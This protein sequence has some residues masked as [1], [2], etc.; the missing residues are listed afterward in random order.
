MILTEKP[1][2]PIWA[3]CE[4][5][6]TIEHNRKKTTW[7]HWQQERKMWVGL[8]FIPQLDMMRWWNLMSSA[9]KK[10]CLQNAH[11]RF[12]TVKTAFWVFSCQKINASRFGCLYSGW[13]PPATRRQT[14]HLTAAQAANAHIVCQSA[15]WRTL[16]LLSQP[17]VGKPS[18]SSATTGAGTHG[19]CR[20]SLWR[21]TGPQ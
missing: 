10:S 1:K 2:Q 18:L 4:F 15:L 14:L 8:W 6:Q 21:P 7:I 17:K 12:K 13:Q 5:C 3:F 19:S 16:R 9:S 11:L 20:H